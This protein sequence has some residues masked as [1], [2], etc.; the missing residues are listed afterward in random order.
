MISQ[1][2]TVP[3]PSFGKLQMNGEVSELAEG[4]RLEI[5]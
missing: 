1:L 4:A 5:A 2:C 3:L